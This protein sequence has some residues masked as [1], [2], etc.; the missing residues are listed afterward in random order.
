LRNTG[1][2]GHEP[3]A[4]I[5]T[6]AHLSELSAAMGLTLLEEL[7]ALI[8]ANYGNYQCYWR[9]L[10]GIPGITLAS[11]DE[12]ERC[13]YQFIVV[14]IDDAIAKISRDQLMKILWAENILAQRYF[15]PGCHRLEPYGSTQ[16]QLRERLQGTERLAQRVLCLPTGTA[17]SRDE[18]RMV[19]QV[20]RFVVENGESVRS[21]LP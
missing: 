15:Y 6:N 14:E 13:N 10:E 4:R 3:I 11:Y 8:D 1:F 12:N 9:E 17:I 21:R 7:P 5:G 20:I 19:C 18:I 2:G 16:P